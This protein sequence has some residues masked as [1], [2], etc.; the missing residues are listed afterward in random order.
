MHIQGPLL[1]P[2]GEVFNEEARLAPRKTSLVGK[3]V[4]L[5]DNTKPGAED[6]LNRYGELLKERQGVVSY[7]LRVK[8]SSTIAVPA[9][10]AEEIRETCNFVITGV[11]D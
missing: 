1:N 3:R 9:D 8:P 10:I 2:R 7:I 11:G 5:L 4:A 6:I